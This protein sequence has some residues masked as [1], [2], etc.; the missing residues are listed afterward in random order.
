[1]S[2][3][4]SKKGVSALTMWNLMLPIGIS[5]VMEPIEGVEPM[6]N[7]TLMV[8]AFVV[9]IVMLLTFLYARYYPYPVVDF[10]EAPVLIII[11]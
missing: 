9:S 4:H 5:I 6:P 1:M 10:L 3:R 8:P 7:W 2:V 11:P